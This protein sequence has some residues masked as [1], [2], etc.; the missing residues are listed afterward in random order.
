MEIS[1][2]GPLGHLQIRY[3]WG[4]QGR[5]P[6]HRLEPLSQNTSGSHLWQQEP[7]GM[8]T[9]LINAPIR[10]ALRW[11]EFGHELLLEVCSA[12]CPGLQRLSG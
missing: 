6:S 5:P 1:F 10:E 2:L 4:Y 9:A 3:P 8:C 7:P 11:Q 12:P